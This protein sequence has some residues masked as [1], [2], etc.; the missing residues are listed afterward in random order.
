MQPEMA[1]SSEVS[2]PSNAHGGSP[3]AQGFLALTVGAIGVVYGDIGTSPI[4]AFREAMI[5]AVDTSGL[6]TPRRR[7]VDLF[8]PA[9]RSRR[10]D[11]HAG[12]RLTPVDKPVRP[13]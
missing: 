1:S 11:R 4:Y 10:R 13:V 9:H 12:S 3:T 7:R 2:A 5:T 6:I 8:P